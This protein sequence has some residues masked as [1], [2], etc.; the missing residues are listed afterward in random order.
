MLFDGRALVTGSSLPLLH[1]SFRLSGR[2]IRDLILS[3]LFVG[4]RPGPSPYFVCVVFSGCC[5]LADLTRSQFARCGGCLIVDL[6]VSEFRALVIGGSRTLLHVGFR[7]RGCTIANLI[8][9]Q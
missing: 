2:L 6:M 4:W 9:S 7:F 1:V 3:Q 8:A 5:L